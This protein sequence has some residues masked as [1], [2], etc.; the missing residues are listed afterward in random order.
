MASIIRTKHVRVVGP[1]PDAVFNDT[2]SVDVV[3]FF[4][5][6]FIGRIGKIVGRTAVGDGAGV[7]DTPSDPAYKVRFGPGWGT[8]ACTELFWT[9]E[10]T[11]FHKIERSNHGRRKAERADQGPA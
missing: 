3:T 2:D 1:G 5:R 4:N 10:L 11:P 6:A 8:S 9:E 7:G